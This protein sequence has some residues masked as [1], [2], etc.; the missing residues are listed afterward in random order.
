[1]IMK[2]TKNR[3]QAYFSYSR[4]PRSPMKLKSRLTQAMITT[5]TA[6]E[7]WP[8]ETALRARPPVM[9]FTDAQPSC[10]ITFNRAIIDDG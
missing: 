4:T 1:M 10:S 3:I 5:P 7:T 6:M 9:Q 8:S 2:I